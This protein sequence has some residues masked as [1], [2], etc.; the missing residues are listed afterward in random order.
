MTTVGQ[1]EK[2]NPGPHRRPAARP[3]GIQRA[4]Y[5]ADGSLLARLAEP[6]YLAQWGVAGA[7]GVGLLTRPHGILEDDTAEAFY[8]H[9]RLSRWEPQ[10]GSPRCRWEA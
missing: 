3:P 2:K 6:A 7:C 9:H 10:G 5:G 1:V 4:I 8:R